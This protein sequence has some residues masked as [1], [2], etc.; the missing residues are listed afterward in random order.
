MTNVLI[1]YIFAA[2]V[3]IALFFFKFWRESGDRLFLAFGVSFLIEGCNRLRFVTL[4][5][6]A[7]GDPSIYVVRSLAFLLIVIAIVMKN[8]ERN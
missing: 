8:R 7:D 2:S 4:H 6:P 3:V 5:N 1:G